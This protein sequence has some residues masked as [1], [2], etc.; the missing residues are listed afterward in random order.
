MSKS[1]DIFE[2]ALELSSKERANLIEKLI[3]SMDQ[4]DE[5]MDA[6]WKDECEERLNKYQQ[7][8]IETQS[9]KE[10]FRRYNR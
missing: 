6:L 5:K 2:Q 8:S 10:V 1:K 7:G 9:V 4:P 3:K